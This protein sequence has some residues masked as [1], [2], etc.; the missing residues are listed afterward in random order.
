MKGK[1]FVISGPSGAGKS[2]I[3]KMVRDIL[4]IPLS[5]SATT[6]KPRVGEMDGKDYYFLTNEEFQEKI[7]NN[8]FFEYML[9]HGNYYGTLLSEIEKNI[10][11]GINLILEIDVKGG[12]LAKQKMPDAILVFCKTQTPEI[13]EKRLLSRN[14]DNL[15]VIT[16]R[17]ENAKEELKYENYYDYV[18][19][20]NNLDES[21]K[22]LINIIQ[23]G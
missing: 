22:E 17:L 21:V 15:D 4:N 18:I 12:V 6:R 1:L 8:E 14:T 2:T 7:N 23:K 3:T 10:D 19:I 20:N 13:L 5:I 9:V 16:T 11:N